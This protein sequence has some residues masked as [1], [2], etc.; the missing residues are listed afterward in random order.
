MKK[1]LKDMRKV[2][3]TLRSAFKWLLIIILIFLLLSFIKDFLDHYDFLVK[4]VTTQTHYIDSLQD[5][6]HNLN[7][8]NNQLIDQLQIEHSKVEQLQQQLSIK[9]NGE[10]VHMSV[11]DIHKEIEPQLKLP[12]ASDSLIP[13]TILTTMTLLKT[14]VFR[15]SF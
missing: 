2:W 11:E 13:V 6:V 8:T 4:K 1:D 3:K 5:T 9:I 14:L 12:S 10:P 7:E 15:F